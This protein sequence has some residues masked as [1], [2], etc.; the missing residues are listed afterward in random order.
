MIPAGRPSSQDGRGARRGDPPRARIFEHIRS[1]IGGAV[2]AL[3]LCLGSLAS[4]P[5]AGAQL[6]STPDPLSLPTAA[7]PMQLSKVSR[8]TIEGNKAADTR[9]ILRT[10]GL[11]EGEVATPTRIRGAINSLYA[12]GLFSQITVIESADS[13]GGRAL[14]L[15]VTENPRI[16]AIDWKGYKKLGEEDLKSKID[17]RAGQLLTRRKLFDAKRAI[18]AA[19]R[20]QG[21]ASA[22]VLPEVK[23]EADGTARL[24]FTIEEGSKVKIEGVDFTGNESFPASELRGKITLRKNSLFHRKRYTAE[25]LKEDEEKLLEFYRNHGHKD[26]KVLASR[27]EFTE[28]RAGVRLFYDLEEGPFYRFGRV[29]WSGNEAV[30]LDALKLASSIRAGEAFSQAKIDLTT[31]DAFNLY[32]EKGY[33][34]QLSIVPETRVVDDT[35][36]VDYSIREGEPSHVHEIGIVGNTRTKERVVRRELS[37]FP[38]D[39]LRRSVLMRS[40]RD[41]FA[42]GYFEDVQVDYKPTGQG[43]DIDVELRVKEKSS[44]TATAGAGYSSDTGVTGFLE[45]GHNNLFGNGQ[46]VSLH[47]ER[48]GRRRTY[49]ISFTEPWFMNTPTSLGFQLYDTQRD[50]DLYTEKRHGFG[51]NLGRPWFWKTPDYTRISGSYSLENVRFSDFIDIDA[52]TQEL[53]KAS[54]GTV[55]SFSTTLS[56]NSTNNPFYPTAGSRTLLRGEWAGGLLGGEVDFFKPMLD[57]RN[58]LVPFWK[59]TLMLRHRLGYLGSYVRGKAVPG[60]ETF[61]LGGTRTDYLRGYPDYEVVP[62]ENIHLGSDGSEV[63]FPGGKVLY[64]F[65]TE[66]QFL[67]VNPVHGVFFFDAGNTWNSAR[68]FSLSDLKKGVG[69]GLRFEIP[70]LGPIGFDYAY[71]IDRGKWEPHLIIGPAF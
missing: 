58:Y 1:A 66:Y 12:L 21:F 53:L 27:A 71:G 43:S 52:E 25:R 63:R 68:D 54:N 3:T 28:D 46:S 15:R 70:L 32:T 64:T 26:A 38:G 41:V 13:T 6:S 59:P 67:I 29:T 4:A 7:S 30:S 14:I 9:L 65:T 16:T 61:R 69:A 49:D 60:N 2:L 10:S 50:L 20:D 47:L 19:Y 62:E 57:H 8:L 45:F 56:R 42:L 39:L 18:E 44:G 34:L 35:V 48:G 5:R 51:I 31:G 23:T 33:L 55:S 36:H 11:A 22:S 24:Q 17:L 40:H 37:L